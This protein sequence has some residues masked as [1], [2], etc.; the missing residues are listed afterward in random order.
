[1]I[2]AHGV[3]MGLSFVI[4]FPLG[5]IIIRFLS[6]IL[7]LPTMIHYITQLGTFLM[8]LAATG[9][10]LYM[11]IGAQF[12]YFHQFFGI[13]IVALIL[14]QGMLGWYHH[15]RFV[16]DKP[17]SRRWFTHLHLWLGRLIIILGLANC[18]FGL[19][20]ADV[21][22]KYAII[23]WCVCGALAI[24]YAALS[25]LRNLSAARRSGVGESFGTATGPGY[26]PQRWKQAEAYEMSRRV[27]PNRI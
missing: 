24:L 8:V 23:W 17:S 22:T 19:I 6:T 25:V 15:H 20:L 12:I 14:V 7:P 5:A 13:I 4:F 27:S 1:M 9:V 10:G 16:R 18:G 21:A 26:S 2:I 11:S 3:L